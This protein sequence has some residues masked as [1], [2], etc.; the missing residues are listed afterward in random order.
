MQLRQFQ[1]TKLGTFRLQLYKGAPRPRLLTF[2]QLP[3]PPANQNFC[4]PTF[5]VSMHVCVQLA[6]ALHQANAPQRA[7]HP[8]IR[9]ID[10]QSAG[11]GARVHHLPWGGECKC[12]EGEGREGGE[13]V[14]RQVHPERCSRTISRQGSCSALPPALTFAPYFPIPLP[15]LL[16]LALPLISSALLA[17]PLELPPLLP[18]ALLLL[19]APSPGATPGPGPSAGAT[20]DQNPIM[21]CHMYTYCR[22]YRCFRWE[23][24]PRR[25]SAEGAALCRQGKS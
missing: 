24:T 9:G 21:A 15:E 20:P 8:G 17:L 6:G 10:L 2:A 11:S 12:W 7:L 16:P 13:G 5:E 18:A 22:L 25:L 19:A 23:M 1:A 14:S 4:S 3:C